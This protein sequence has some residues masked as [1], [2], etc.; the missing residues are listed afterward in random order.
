M[1]LSLVISSGMAESEQGS[2]SKAGSRKEE[3][4]LLARMEEDEHLLDESDGDDKLSDPL[5]KERAKKDDRANSVGT[6]VKNFIKIVRVGSNDVFEAPANSTEKTASSRVTALPG[7]E[8]GNGLPREYE[9][10]KA[11]RRNW[12]SA[13][14]MS[15]IGPLSRKIATAGRGFETGSFVAA[16]D[17]RHL[18]VKNFHSLKDKLNVS[19]SFD[20]KHMVCVTCKDKHVILPEGGGGGPVCIVL[21]DQNFCPFVPAGRGEKCMLV[22]RAEDGLL[23]DLESIFKDVY[24]NFC[25]PEGVLPAGSV[26]LIGSASHVTLLGLSTYAEDYVRVNNNLISACGNGV[27][28]CPLVLVPLSG[29]KNTRAVEQLADLDSW[30]MSTNLPRNIGLSDS[31]NLL[32]E[33]LCSSASDYL[34]KGPTC[35]VHYLPL[36]LTNPRKRRFSAGPLVGNF[37]VEILPLD[38]DAESAIV[39]GLIRELNDCYCLSLPATPA[40][41]RGDGSSLDEPEFKKLVMVGGSHTSR[42][43]ALVS[44]SIETVCLKLPN[45]SQTNA[46]KK[47][48]QLANEMSNLGLAKGDCVYIDALSNQLF[49]GSDEDGLPTEPERDG[50]GKWHITGSLVA[51]PKPRLKKLLM[52]LAPLRE[53]SGDATIVC[54]LPL[55]RYISAKCCK[56]ESHLENRGDEDFG[57]I[58][59]TAIASCRGCLETAFPGCAVFNPTDSFADADGDM[60]NLISSAGISIWLEDDPVHLTNTA[61]GDIA[62]S[63]IKL[64]NKT[65]AD[66]SADQLHRP[67]LESVVT[68]PREVTVANSTPGWILGEAQQGGR[69]RGAPGRGFGGSRGF[70]GRQAPFR[71]GATRWVPY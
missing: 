57:Q 48:L 12:L 11:A 58:L 36:S 28:V 38:C 55:G 61:Y 3:D 7:T 65:A 20:P 70:R 33:T 40:L 46:D 49:M 52:Q 9:M 24:R 51:A 13:V 60:A 43:S 54:G 62:A 32:W 42:M 8:H 69:G 47:I 6:L 14:A 35:A 56:D 18:A 1:Q 5:S 34:E 67:R 39:G 25:R 19:M 29:V 4:E 66:P 17:H 30:I 71:G 15:G 26:I 64:V 53:A 2:S 59:R 27:T 22:I 21:S 31:R 16:A 41:C 45:Q 68:R 63:L 44:A 23:S 10:V 37:P 50:E